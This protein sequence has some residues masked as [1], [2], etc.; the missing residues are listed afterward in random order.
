MLCQVE[1]TFNLRTRV[2]RKSDRENNCLVRLTAG[3]S[4]AYDRQVK[5]TQPEPDCQVRLSGVPHYLIPDAAAYLGVSERQVYRWFD[6]GVLTKC[7]YPERDS[8]GVCVAASE[9]HELDRQRLE[10]RT[11][12]HRNGA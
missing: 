7:R 9:V 6:D 4:R 3:P 10:E 8:G 5:L 1:L 2:C 12:E 11:H